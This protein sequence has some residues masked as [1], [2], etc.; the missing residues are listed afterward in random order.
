MLANLH[1]QPKLRVAVL[2]TG[3][4]ALATAASLGM[5]SEMRRERDSATHGFM[6]F[7]SL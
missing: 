2:V 5:R 7:V 1:V 6:L 4:D 3:G